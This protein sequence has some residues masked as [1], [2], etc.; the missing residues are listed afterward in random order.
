[1]KAITIFALAL[2]TLSRPC[3][4]EYLDAGVDENNVPDNKPMSIQDE[5][6]NNLSEAQFK[7][8]A[9]QKVRLFAGRLQQELMTAIKS[10]GLIY[11]VD[12]CQ[13]QAPLIAKSLST[14]GWQVGRTSL[15]TRNIANQADEW[16]LAMLAQ[17][18]K[19]NKASEDA[20]QLTAFKKDE[21][22]LRYMKAIP[23]QQVCLACHGSKVDPGL[24]D[25]INERY[26]EDRAIGFSLSDIRGAFTLTKHLSEDQQKEEKL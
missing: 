12:V 5:Q 3:F 10:G 22:Y 13:S 23:T 8:E 24:R 7:I 21:R 1:M 26:Q 15:K 17:F 18:E 9:Q 14:D 20:N 25:A 11:T 16:E 19:R 2:L 4:S 6:S